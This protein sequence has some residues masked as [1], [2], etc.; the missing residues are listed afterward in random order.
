M[1]AVDECVNLY[2]VRLLLAWGADHTGVRP[3][4]NRVGWLTSAAKELS[5]V[6]KQTVPMTEQEREAA[7]GEWR[8]AV[9]AANQKKAVADATVQAVVTLQAAFD[10]F[11]AAPHTLTAD[12]LEAALTPPALDAWDVRWIVL[13]HHVLLFAARID[14][15]GVETDK[16][17]EARRVHWFGRLYQPVL[18]LRTLTPCN[19]ATVSSLV[20]SAVDNGLLEQYHI[21]VAGM[22]L[23]LHATFL[24]RSYQH[25]PSRCRRGGDGRR[26]GRAAAQGHQGRPQPRAVYGGKAGARPQGGAGH[27][28]RQ[29]CDEPRARRR[30][31]PQRHHRRGGR[32]DRRRARRGK[33][34]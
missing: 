22:G 29:D 17:A 13:A 14:V 30:R 5:D 31:R 27:V 32:A 1:M 34:R 16:E 10:G 12:A 4:R 28:R 2:L 6:I 15:F 24:C 7:I 18:T 20:R 9:E 33:V 19:R 8:A 3:S 21:S 23:Q 25:A 26:R 11:V